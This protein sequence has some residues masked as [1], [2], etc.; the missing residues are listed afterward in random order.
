MPTTTREENPLLRASSRKA[1]RVTPLPV[2]SG[3]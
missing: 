1:R 3:L 2:L